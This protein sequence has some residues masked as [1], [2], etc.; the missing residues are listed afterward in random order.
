MENRG[1]L[2]HTG[3][4]IQKGLN[5]D[6]D[7]LVPPRLRGSAG[8]LQFMKP[9][10][11]HSWVYAC[12]NAI[13]R[14]ISQLDFVLAEKKNPEKIETEHEFL[15]LIKKPNPYM[16]GSDLIKFTVLSL[17][18]PT[19]KTT[20]GQC[21]WVLEPKQGSRVNLKRGEIP[22]EIYPF[23]DECIRPIMNS[24]KVLIGWKLKLPDGTEVSYDL[25]S[26]LRFKL[27]NPY[28]LTRG[29][30]PMNSAL[31]P[32]E[33]DIKSDALNN[34]FFDNN[35]SLGGILTTDKMLADAQIKQLGESWKQQYGGVSNAGS[36]AIL[37]SGLKYEAMAKT[38]AEMLFMEQKQWTVDIIRAV[39]GV[40]KFAVGL[41]EDLNFATAEVAKRFFWEET[42]IPYCKEICTTITASMVQFIDS[43]KWIA[44]FDYSNVEAL[45]DKYQSKI[46]S[47][48]QMVDRGVPMDRAS[49]LLRIPLDTAHAM[50][51]SDPLVKGQV[52]NI[53]TGE[54][55]GGFGSTP[56]DPS[57]IDTTK[58][59]DTNKPKKTL[60]VTTSF[61]GIIKDVEEERA[62]MDAI[63]FDYVATTLDPGEKKMEPA[64]KG[65]FF[66][67]RNLVQD[68]IDRWFKQKKAL[69]IKA[70]DL[71]TPEDLLPDQTE[72]DVKLQK[73][74]EPIY[75]GQVSVVTDKVAQ[76]IGDLINWDTASPEAK[77]IIS[78]RVKYLKNINN[79][80]FK[81][82]GKEIG[83]VI[84]QA[85]NEDWSTADTI[86]E[87]KKTVGKVYEI[88][89]NQAK[90]I[91]R[92]EIAAVSNETRHA[93]FLEEGIQFHKW[94]SARDKKVRHDHNKDTGD[95]GAI[96]EI[97]KVFPVT[98]ILYPHA[99][100]APARQAINC[101]CMTVAAKKP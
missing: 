63:W 73:I 32:I 99:P 57:V 94:I 33:G 80:T 56:E 27:L 58:P 52:V 72:E 86:K 85:V 75:V 100:K 79:T 62:N 82:A 7:F 25:N 81:K 26:I 76:E 66:K 11:Q 38:H 45:Q 1:L 97:G 18:L 69:K 29:L 14:N 40:P 91:A 68:N 28:D 41:Y 60:A 53:E 71:P 51:M 23:S 13:A 15:S 90:T 5:L 50:Y 88:R 36:T 49:K 70:E 21:F 93:I 61:D 17:L 42:I 67:Q 48:S 96:V 78:T 47:W 6:P 8:S 3:A 34:R 43:G 101:R 95:D 98:G 10:A 74:I 16:D 12:T 65:F 46:L 84:E 2:D 37:H 39:Y 55:L 59:A 22:F 4:P 54:L 19:T 20:G 9:Y 30:S 64:M 77:K 31:V 92:T 24:D 87:L 89:T 83:S 35:A 44:T